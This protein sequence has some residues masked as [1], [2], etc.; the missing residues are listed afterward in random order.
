MKKSIFNISQPIE[1]GVLV[2]NTFTTS[3]VELPNELY[4]KIFDEDDFS[5]PEVSALY[6]MGFLVEDAI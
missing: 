5:L 4:K 3:L 1:S 6:S 2:Y